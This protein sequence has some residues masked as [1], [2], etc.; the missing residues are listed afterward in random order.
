MRTLPQTII[1][2]F[3]FAATCFFLPTLQALTTRAFIEINGASAEHS[4]VYNNDAYPA[5]N[6]F[7]GDLNTFTHT[8]N[9]DPEPT[10]T[11]YFDTPHQAWGILLYNR[12]DCCQARLQ[13]VTVSVYKNIEDEDPI[14]SDIY[15]VDNELGSPPYIDVYFGQQ[16]TFQ[17]IVVSIPGYLSEAFLSLGEVR[18]YSL[19]EN[20]ELPHN[21]NLTQAGITT[22]TVDQSTTG[23]GYGPNL[24]IDGIYGNFT[25][26]ATS[27]AEPY[28]QIDFGED[29][30]FQRVKIYNRTDCC[31]Q[32]LR[33]ITV[34]VL[35]EN[36]N[37][38]WASP[39]LN[40]GNIQSSP[41]ELDCYIQ[42]LNGNQP[43][44]G[45]IVRISRATLGEN[46]D[47]SNALSLAEVEIFG[48][49]PGTPIPSIDSDN[50]GLPDEWELAH[51]LNPNDPSD[52]DA[53][54]DEDLLTNRQEFLLG[55]DPRKGDTDGDGLLDHVETG[56]GQWVS[57]SDTGTSPF[58]ADTDGDGLLDGQENPDLE[59]NGLAQPGT[60]PNMADTDEDGW[61]DLVEVLFGSHPRNA[62]SLP[63]PP[64][65]RGLLAYWPFD[66]ASNPTLAVEVTHGLHG[67]LL[68]AAT[69]TEDGGGRTGT[70][71][72]RA[73]DFGAS[74]AISTVKAITGEFLN[75]T[76]VNDQITISFWQKLHQVANSRPFSAF[77]VPGS[78]DRRGISAHTTWSN[79]NF[80][81]DTSGCCDESAQRI[82]TSNPGYDLTE[83]H[84]F[85]FLKMG[86]IKQIWIDGELL[87]EGYNYNPLPDTFKTL[88]IGSS[89]DGIENLRGIID[90]FAIYATALSES[91]I[92]LLGSGASPVTFGQPVINVP[93]LAITHVSYQNVT[94]T[95]TWPSVSG[96]TY[97][98]QR[99]E[100][101][102]SGSWDT[103]ATITATGA[104]TTWT[105]TIAP[106]P[107]T[108]SVYFY[109]VTK[110][111]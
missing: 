96:A 86:E 107:S 77:F 20:V 88:F 67:M 106:L 31:P 26:T 28:W 98:V 55:T 72:D 15:N 38:L 69:Y 12:S 65:G 62:A 80:Y 40:P 21:T 53:H 39:L 90:D 85:V 81:W 89:E 13:S 32:R 35:D 45:R 46:S 84:H 97:T 25:H 66:D 110:E 109:R 54:N 22:I 75:F 93:D 101:L 14:F 102:A 27:D 51:G 95:L 78:G 58:L 87:L 18:L 44:V 49:S 79:N 94:L 52:A 111:N 24:A 33:D 36:E 100:T 103:I 41:M 1:K 30:S 60:D 83:W 105:D 50:D 43:V 9:G 11:G 57:P 82:W 47:D 3:V 104:S 74:Q 73:I 34:Q 71:G 48:G 19:N 17:K 59:P 2:H 91:D 8:G 61:G 4:S 6:A 42:A 56:T 108:K 76:A 64:G 99:S 23:Y 92:Q 63:T 29:M 5:T 68:G 7:D 70:P 16:L 37:E 10:W